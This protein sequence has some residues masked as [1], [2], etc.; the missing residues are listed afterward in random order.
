MMVKTM[1]NDSLFANGFILDYIFFAVELDDGECAVL[2]IELWE[3]SLEGSNIAAISDITDIE[4][5]VASRE[6]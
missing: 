6:G 3:S 5:S 4:F 1:P 2:D